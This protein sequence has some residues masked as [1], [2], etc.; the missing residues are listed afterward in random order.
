MQPSFNEQMANYQANRAIFGI[1]A[2]FVF[3]LI[4]IAFEA[5]TKKKKKMYW[6]EENKD[7]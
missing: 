2:C 7:E 1:F 6:E 4:Y 3:F 5:F